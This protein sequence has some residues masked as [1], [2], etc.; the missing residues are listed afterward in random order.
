MNPLQNKKSSRDDSDWLW[1]GEKEE[2]KL[3]SRQSIK[4][5]GENARVYVCVC[6]CSCL[7]TAGTLHLMGKGHLSLHWLLM[8]FPSMQLSDCQAWFTIN[9]HQLELYM[10]A[11][12]SHP[13]KWRW[14]ARRCRSRPIYPWRCHWR[15]SQHPGQHGKQKKTDYNVFIAAE[16]RKSGSWVGCWL[17]IQALSSSLLVSCCL[18]PRT[19]THTSTHTHQSAFCEQPLLELFVC[20]E[21]VHAYPHFQV[22]SSIGIARNPATRA[23]R[24]SVGPIWSG[25]T[26]RRHSAH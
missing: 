9:Q 2:A 15:D 26:Q 1:M 23:L 4:I 8:H 13:S 10:F 22:H 25:H 24:Y 12:L 6:V 20:D 18:L 14:P 16:R 19:G 3:K 21:S 17:K 7:Y 11:C 5:G